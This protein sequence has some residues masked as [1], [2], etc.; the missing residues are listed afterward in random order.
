MTFSH[1]CRSSWLSAGWTPPDHPS[2]LGWPELQAE[3]PHDQHHYLLGWF[4]LA[5]VPDPLAHHHCYL[6]R[7]ELLASEVPN[8]RRRQEVCAAFL[9]SCVLGREE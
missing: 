2:H 5:K 7:S 1:G 4:E 8:R 9:S 6:R 3:A